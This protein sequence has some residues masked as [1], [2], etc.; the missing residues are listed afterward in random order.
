M[1][2]L[3]ARAREQAAVLG[4][5]AR[6]TAE[7]DMAE[8]YRQLRRAVDLSD[9]LRTWRAVANQLEE[10][11][12]VEPQPS[13]RV[14]RTAVLGT[15]TTS[16]FVWLLH[17]AGFRERVDLRVYEGPYGQVE[18]EI[19]DTTSGLYA[20][21][22][23]VVV[24]AVHDGALRLPSHSDD[25]A[26]DVAREVQRWIALRDTVATRTRAHII[27]HNVAVPPVR[28]FGNLSA[29]LPGS[30]PR[31]ISAFNAALADAA[32]D[33]VAIVDCDW[34]AGSIGTET[35]FDDRYWHLAKQAVAPSAIP[36]LAH[37][38]AAVIAA[39]HGLSR[40]CLVLDLDGT[41]WGG[42]V[43]E[44]GPAG[45]RIGD[46]PIG[47]AFAAFQ[48]YL[49]QL[50]DRGVLLAVCSKNNEADAVE[51]F[52]QHPAMRIRL[53]DI[54]AFVTNWE[55][56]PHNLRRIAD[57]LDIG[58][59]ALV[60]VDDNPAEREVIRKLV[61]EV[62]VVDLPTDPAG[63]GRA[64]ARCLALEP[65]WFTA[66]DGGRTMQYRARA[67][68]A[69]L[70]RSEASLEDFWRSLRMQATVAPF[71]DLHLPRI[72]QL[73][74]KT[75]QFN[76]TTPR[77][78]PADVQARMADPQYVCQYLKLRDRFADHGLVG[79][80]IARQDGDTLDIDTWLMSC[81]VIGRTAD[82][83]MLMHLCGEAETRRCSHLVG[84]YIPTAKNALVAEVFE[85]FGFVLVEKANDGT[86]RWMYD[87][88]AEGPIRNDFCGNG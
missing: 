82:A 57:M 54:A 75:N 14:L 52:E 27:Q 47:E 71:D 51:V 45:I 23:E 25:P 13:A 61:P 44:D 76:L 24:I 11:E 49:L 32:G 48:D 83:E 74:G 70:A 59:D 39:R 62:E 50:R 79:V 81:R 64:V 8:A 28:A 42:V 86:T 31:M 37:H 87:L 80:L 66:E 72:V 85:R 78:G 21:D 77:Y 9:G 34:L 3:D 65:A 17:V 38:T 26:R 22:P 73:I 56:K 7:R 36:R 20:G 69:E 41:L 18:Q 15:Y 53:D 16:Q 58:V 10:A 19:L 55:P 67:A 5:S 63:F 33:R 2:A 43:G 60:F 84:T 4:A 88:A 1:S 12:A 40:K 30:R 35:W 29:R 68:A 6:A 46:G